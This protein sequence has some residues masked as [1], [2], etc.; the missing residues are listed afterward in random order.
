MRVL[1]VLLVL[2][3]ICITLSRW[4]FT[5]PEQKLYRQVS[6]VMAVVFSAVFVFI[7]GMGL[8]HSTV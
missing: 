3:A 2:I 6:I 7:L 5:D 1:I 8:I 4:V